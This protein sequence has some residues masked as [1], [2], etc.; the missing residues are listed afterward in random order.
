MFF[1]RKRLRLYFFAL[2][3]LQCLIT[4][5]CWRFVREGSLDFRTF[6][7][8][9]H[10]VLSGHGAQLYDYNTQR[11]AQNHAVTATE[12]ALTLMEPPFTVLMFV[13]LALLPFL[14]A[15]F[16]FA[17]LNLLL[18]GVAIWLMWPYLPEMRTRMKAAPALLFL[19]F[20]PL[21]LSLAQGQLSAMLLALYCG[22]FVALKKQREVLAGLLIA[23]AT[24]KFQMA[25]PIALLFLLWRR[26]RFVWG[27][28]A[29]AAVLA[30][31]SVAV[32]GFGHAGV[33]VHAMSTAGGVLPS[34]SDQ[35]RFGVYPRNMPNLYGLFYVLSGGARWGVALAAAASVALI[36]WAARHKPSLPLAL[37][38]AML[39]S[40][41]LYS[42]DLALLLLP[43][44]LLGEQY[45]IEHDRPVP[46]EEEPAPAHWSLV[47]GTAAIGMLFVTPVMVYFIAARGL[48][49]LAIPIAWITLT[50]AGRAW[51]RKQA[52][53]QREGSVLHELAAP[54][55]A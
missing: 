10:I 31:L 18:V 55:A 23:L 2:V 53:E 15:Y 33:Y 20:L 40:Y 12:W 48:P 21:G 25:L 41:H 22:A 27:F 1:T 16:A 7:G 34:A 29:G 5:S 4:A 9:G 3:F 17:A 11:E 47:V 28:A 13:P 42:H 49:F 45:L 30:L 50:V 51:G 43:L 38:V 24:M 19:T 35:I 8:A 32:L 37:M 44:S 36:M 46:A 54:D 52:S 14:A 39:V 26:W 6:L